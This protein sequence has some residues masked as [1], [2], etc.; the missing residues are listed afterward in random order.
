MPIEVEARIFI[1]HLTMEVK[2]VLILFAAI[3][4]CSHQ[5]VVESDSKSVPYLTKGLLLFSAEWFTEFQ[6]QAKRGCGEKV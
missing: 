6:A 5:C 1:K 3:E 2:H 4:N